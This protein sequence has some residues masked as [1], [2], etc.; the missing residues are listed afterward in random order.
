[1]IRKDSFFQTRV[2]EQQ[3]ANLAKLAT[4]AQGKDSQHSW[5]ARPAPTLLMVQ[6]AASNAAMA[7]TVQMRGLHKRPMSK[8]F[9]M[10]DSS[11]MVLP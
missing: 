5:S 10:Q 3:L 7:T 6:I 11:V 1:M 9:V 2:K 4:I 8:L